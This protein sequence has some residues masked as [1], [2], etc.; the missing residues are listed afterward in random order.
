M[1]P[2]YLMYIQ[3]AKGKI[4][5]MLILDR[6]YSYLIEKSFTCEVSIL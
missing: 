2:L 1:I 6:F 3:V 4:F 5:E